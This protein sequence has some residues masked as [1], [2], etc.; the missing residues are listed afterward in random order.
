MLGECLIGIN[1]ERGAVF[2]RERGQGNVLAVEPV[3]AINEKVH[4]LSLLTR[5][6]AFR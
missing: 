5:K 3:P 6:K 2:F 1:V 4:P